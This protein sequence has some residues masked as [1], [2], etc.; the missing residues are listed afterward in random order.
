MSSTSST[1]PE[2][3]LKTV[4]DNFFPYES[5][6]DDQRTGI[7]NSLTAFRDGGFHTL[8]GPCGTG[9]TLISAVSAIAAI[10]DPS[11]PYRRALVVT[12]VKQ[13]QAA[14]ESD[15]KEIN[16]HII[17]KW[18]HQKKAPKGFKPITAQTI[19][20]KGDLCPFTDSA[21]ISPNS[22]GARCSELMTNT[23]DVASKKGEIVDGAQSIILSATSQAKDEHSAQNTT[24]QSRDDIEY[25]SISD[26]EFS[27]SPIYFGDSEVCPYYAQHLIDRETN[28]RTLDY[29]G[30]VMDAT[31]LR[32]RATELGTCPYTAM[33]TG[34]KDA[35]I[36]IGNYAHVFHRG[37]IEAFTHQY[38]DP[39]TL[40]IVDEAHMLIERVQDYLSISSSITD[41]NKAISHI[42]TI[43][44]Q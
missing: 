41:F 31:S 38:I 40:L 21:A 37:T 28:N 18:G 8:E 16:E 4:I 7:K 44:D 3:D 10:R 6:Y 5:P 1:D 32:Q 34:L 23:T 27:P 13:Q 22:I 2:Y 36:I 12:S 25:D 15:I 26:A 35:E 20:G 9:K 42:E 14:F 30:K 33:K 17:D 19:V 43:E 39:T 11:T 29:D 24:L